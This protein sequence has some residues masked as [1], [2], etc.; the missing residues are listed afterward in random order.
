MQRG[1]FEHFS[2]TE[3]ERHL[4]FESRVMLPLFILIDFSIVAKSQNFVYN[5]KESINRKLAALFREKNM[6]EH[7]EGQYYG[8][9]L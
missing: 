2:I 6:K 5:K 9:G 8:H 4:R 1:C 3:R 7:K